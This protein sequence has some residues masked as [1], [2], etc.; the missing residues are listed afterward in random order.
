MVLLLVAF[1]HAEADL[2]R[3]REDAGAKQ[4]DVAKASQSIVDLTNAFR[5]EQGL[6]E[7]KV[8]D[9]L[10]ATAK[11]FAAFMAKELKYGH[12]A[13]GKTPSDRATASRY[14]YALVLENIAYQFQSDG[15][16][17]EQL[18]T[19]LTV[20]WQNSPGHRKNMLDPDVTET[21]VA[22]ARSEGGIYFAVQMFGRPKSAMIEIKVTNKSRKPIRYT[23]S[24]E[25]FDLRAR[26]GRTHGVARPPTITFELPAGSK[27]PDE[28]KVKPLK[29]TTYTIT[30]AGDGVAVTVR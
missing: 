29:A 13:D 23:L 16:S 18:G 7:V 12:E 5:R 2:T 20:G 24:G 19:D 3:M 25:S 6:A 10:D 1:A 9:R 22:I 11:A 4:A 26:A 14:D 8:N 27:Q 15:I 28:S 30:D 17:T 21:G